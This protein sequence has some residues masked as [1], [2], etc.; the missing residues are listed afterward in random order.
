M[1]IQIW[2]YKY[3]Y[4]NIHTYIHTYHIFRYVENKEFNFRFTRHFM[5]M[6]SIWFASLECALTLVGRILPSDLSFGLLAQP[7]GIIECNIFATACYFACYD[8]SLD[9]VS[10][11]FYGFPDLC[12][13]P[14]PLSASNWMSNIMG[15]YCQHLCKLLKNGIPKQ[16]KEQPTAKIELQELL[17]AT[18]FD[19][20][21]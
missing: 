8:F 5:E 10:I 20:F 6:A 17:F 12:L 14:H 9:F 7:M 21:L 1:H 13:R 3:R 15:A 4:I 11:W 16:K 19:E 2:V 18:K